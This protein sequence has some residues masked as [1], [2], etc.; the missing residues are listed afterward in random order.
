MS[1]RIRIV[2]CYQ[3]TVALSPE[4]EAEVFIDQCQIVVVTEPEEGDAS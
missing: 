2:G 4:N 1:V 3:V